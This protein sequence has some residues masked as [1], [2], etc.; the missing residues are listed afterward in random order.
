MAD[1]MGIHG[2]GIGGTIPSPIRPPAMAES[3]ET[4]SAGATGKAESFKDVLFAKIEQVNALQREADAAVTEMAAGG[5][6]R[7]VADV[8]AAV[9]KADLA[10]QTLL[11]IQ[12]KLL[13]AY[14]EISQMRI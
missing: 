13:A 11:Q 12:G 8:M 14:E 6:A 10:F 1:G 4:L 3:G 9:Q 7:N 2:I 5:R